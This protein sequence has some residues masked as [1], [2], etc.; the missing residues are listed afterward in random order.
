MVATQLTGGY[1]F[2]IQGFSVH[3]GPGCR[4]LIFFKGCPMNCKWCSNP[5]GINPWSEPLHSP[6]KC[7]MDQLCA[8]ACP[9]G[10]IKVSKN[11]LVID[12]K[13][14]QNCS[15]TACMD[16]C[17]SGAIRK[18][19]FF[20]TPEDLFRKISR[21]RQYWGADGGIT[22]TG[23]EPFRQP[24]F[25]RDILKL[26]YDAFI[27]TS[28]ETC[29]NVPWRN[30]SA[31]VDLLEWIFYDLKQI[32]PEKH[33]EA[34]GMDNKTIL[35][36]ARLLADKF[37]GRL[38]FRIP[39]IPGFNDDP[40]SISELGDF[41]LTTGRKEVNII[42]VHH[43]GREK[44]TLLGKPYYTEDFSIPSAKSLTQISKTFTAASLTCYVGSDTPF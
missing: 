15:V 32:H 41:I 30:I 10:A 39:L 14:C 3:D 16:S 36:N 11:S 26:C 19:G 7:T 24:D 22:L 40:R 4:T 43:L 5:E 13:K 28:V 33:K 34:T 35:K 29:G 12:R 21:D 44:H 42:P 2:D 20:I 9:E 27:H 37:N 38:I 1:L 31:S 23:G 8:K 17:Y 18:A 25:A 6:A